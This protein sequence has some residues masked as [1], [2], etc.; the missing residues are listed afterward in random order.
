FNID[1]KIQKQI[2]KH[3][4]VSLSAQNLLDEVHINDGGNKTPGRFI[5]GKIAWQL[6]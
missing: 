4:L 3:W 6:F 5:I 1:I 2:T